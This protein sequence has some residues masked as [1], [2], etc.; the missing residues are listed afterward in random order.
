MRPSTKGW[1]DAQQ[2]DEHCTDETGHG[3]QEVRTYAVFPAPEG[4]D[5][6]GL[7]QDLSAVGVTFSERTDSRGRTSL[8]GR[9]SILSRQ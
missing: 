3:R 8:G 2:I 1:K 7:W 4:V 6:E 9:Y 5:P